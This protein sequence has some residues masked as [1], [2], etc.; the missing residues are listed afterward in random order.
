MKFA[1]AGTHSRYTEVTAATERYLIQTLRKPTVLD[2][3]AK[4]SEQKKPLMLIRSPISNHQSSPLMK[5]SLRKVSI[6][7]V[8]RSALAV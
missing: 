7:V 6:D 3:R 8:N 2:V 1:F 5:Q 4:N